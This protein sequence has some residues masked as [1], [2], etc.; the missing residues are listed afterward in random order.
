MNPQ[1]DPEARIRD[2]ERPLSEVARSSELG[3]A[4]YPGGYGS[5]PPPLPPGYYGTPFPTPPTRGSGGFSWWWLIVAA[6][7]V[8]LVAIGAGVAVFGSNMFSA[9]SP[10]S[11]G[12]G[13]RPNI[14]GGGGTLTN[15]PSSGPTVPGGKTQM[16]GAEPPVAVEPSVDV[17]PPGG[18]VGVSGIG[19]NKTIACNDGT[20]SV[21]GV[22]NTVVIT[23]H[24]TSLTVSGMDNLI[25]VDSAESIDTSGFDNRV[26]FKSGSPEVNKSGAGNVVEPG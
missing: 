15:A 8:G 11:S 1:D 21:S 22:D 25:T 9:S 7:V 16:P 14:S 13:D 4:Q 18:S 10:F 24:C 17:V 20:V 5:A 12:S 19:E 26:T 3:T 2:L 23:G 6:F